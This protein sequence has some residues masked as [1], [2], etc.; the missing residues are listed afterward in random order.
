[1]RLQQGWRFVPFQISNWFL[2]HI[3]KLCP[4][5]LNISESQQNTNASDLE[6]FGF[7][8]LEDYA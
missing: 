4:E 2:N 6:Q 1:M 7:E 3:E 8:F 5:C